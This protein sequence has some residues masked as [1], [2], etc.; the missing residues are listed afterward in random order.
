M[1]IQ[2]STRKQYNCNYYFVLSATYPMAKYDQLSGPDLIFT[3]S[4]NLKQEYI[5]I[6]NSPNS[7]RV[8]SYFTSERSNHDE[9]LDHLVWKL[10]LH[11]FKCLTANNKYH[12]WWN[13]YKAKDSPQRLDVV[14]CGAQNGP[15]YHWFR[16]DQF[17][18]TAQVAWGDSS[19]TASGSYGGLS[20]PPVLYRNT[21]AQ[22]QLG[23][24]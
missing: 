13:L 8:R 7:K 12:Q 21:K 22:R 3:T 17:V 11:E 18:R 5:S 23:C 2:I 16:V 24:H 15:D 9:S 10:N 4:I 6:Q 20:G 1:Y 14:L 19:A